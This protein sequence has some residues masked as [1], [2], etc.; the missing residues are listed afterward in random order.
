[1]EYFNK[2]ATVRDVIEARNYVVN[3]VINAANI[4][5]SVLLVFSMIWILERVV[6]H[7]WW[8]WVIAGACYAAAW[9]YIQIRPSESL[10]KSGER[11][12]DTPYETAG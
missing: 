12:E 4:I 7:H 2:P 8:D 6:N 3:T 5:L 9:H 10:K 1:M 11:I